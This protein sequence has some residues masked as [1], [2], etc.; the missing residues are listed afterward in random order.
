LDSRQLDLRDLRQQFGVVMQ[1]P[2]LFSGSVRQNIVL[3]MPD[4][5]M[6]RVRE[7][8]RLAVIDEMIDSL[9]MGYETIL[10]EDAST[11]SGGQ[12]QRLALAR[13]LAASPSILLLDEA[14]SH[15]DPLTEQRLDENLNT[16]KCT[17]IVIAHR[18][19][20]VRNADLIVVL[21]QG[22]IIE[23]GTHERLMARDG[24][25]A[26]LVAPN[27]AFY[28]RNLPPSVFGEPGYSPC[29]WIFRTPPIL[30]PGYHD[31]GIIRIIEL[32]RFIG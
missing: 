31:S 30:L 4:L 16:L 5:S 22:Y 18:L 7:A 29:V 19:S 9:P 20:T 10:S 26:A 6:P 17:R 3:N 15:L 28:Q 11:I 23:C 32:I 25:Y 2:F 8:A 1:D 24:E 27:K 14:T 12:R 13:A 21:D